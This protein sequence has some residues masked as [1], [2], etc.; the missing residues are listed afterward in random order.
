MPDP[1][2][3]YHYDYGTTGVTVGD[4]SFQDTPRLY[5]RV[6]KINYTT[7]YSC[8]DVMEISVTHRPHRHPRTHHLTP[9]ERAGFH[10]SACKIDITRF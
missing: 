3:L 8:T 6:C 2:F 5:L 10:P 9:C 4:G 7:Q 1:Q